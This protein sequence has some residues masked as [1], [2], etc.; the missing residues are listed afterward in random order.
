MSYIINFLFIKIKTN[1]EDI[2]TIDPKNI[3]H[4]NYD[5]SSIS[6]LKNIKLTNQ[7]IDKIINTKT[8]FSEFN[9]EQI[10]IEYMKDNNINSN[11][12]F[13]KENIQKILEALFYQGRKLELNS[14]NYVIGSY[15]WNNKINKHLVSRES[16]KKDNEFTLTITLK[17]LKKDKIT[18]IDKRR[19]SCDERYDQIRKD[20]RDIFSKKNKNDKNVEIPVVK[21]LNG[22][23]R[24]YKTKKKRKIKKKSKKR[25]YKKTK[26]GGH[27]EWLLLT[28]VALYPKKNKRKKY[29]L[30]K[31]KKKKKS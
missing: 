14:E 19:I 20:T 6:Y 24:K 30:N 13:S 31:T 28:A 25:M 1:V 2:P 17:L 10:A 3:K 4:N 5:L 29:G 18:F 27:H 16:L 11:D 7:M 23:K 22:G 21:P 8:G 15:E 9:L 26:K 12:D